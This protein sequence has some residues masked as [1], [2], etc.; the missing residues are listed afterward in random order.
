MGKKIVMS[1]IH[2]GIDDSNLD[3]DGQNVRSNGNKKT[4]DA[5]MK[6]LE[7]KEIKAD[8]VI[9][10][11]DLFDLHLSNFSRAL[12]GSK[13]FFEQ[14]NKLDCLKNIVYV[15]GN[16]DHNVWLLHVLQNEIL[17]KFKT[18]PYLIAKDLIFVNKKYV[19][20]QSFLKSLFPNKKVVI[21]YPKFE[22]KRNVKGSVKK[23]ML[24]HGHYVD[25]WQGIA[26]KLLHGLAKLQ[27][28]TQFRSLQDLELFSS[29]QYETIFLL[30]N[31]PYARNVLNALNDLLNYT[32]LFNKPKPIRKLRTI[33]DTHFETPGYRD[34][35]PILSDINYLIIGH[36]HKAGL[37][38]G[39][40]RVKYPQLI[41]MNSGCWVLNKDK[42]VFG[43]FI[44]IDDKDDNIPLGYNFRLFNPRG[45]KEIG[46]WLHDEWFKF[47]EVDLK[48]GNFFKNIPTRLPRFKR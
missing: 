18:D 45:G 35:A 32:N 16:H 20:Q 28:P 38:Q 19:D 10:L 8:T 43:N 26:Y 1:D 30:A 17:E 37:D 9:F 42:V 40:G 27:V 12:K 41:T 6:H 13:Y 2:F 34:T 47:H 44:E 21:T 46:A 29:P 5:F 3:V 14:L 4:I 24:S 39:T 11:G 23:I 7:S 36:T 31:S 33:I 15:P 48:K 22:Y 25:E